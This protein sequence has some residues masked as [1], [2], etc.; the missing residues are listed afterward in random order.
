MLSVYLKQVSPTILI[1]SIRVKL[2]LFNKALGETAKPNLIFLGND[3]TI[4]S[5]SVN[6]SLVDS[7]TS[8]AQS[9]PL[10][11]INLGHIN[12][13]PLNAPSI[14]KNRFLIIV[15]IKL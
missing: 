8:L 11:V 12:Q 7:T 6:S 4:D 9:H 5:I 1:F 15:Q 10:E 13:T 3:S 2:S 14:K